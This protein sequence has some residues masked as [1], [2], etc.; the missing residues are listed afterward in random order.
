[1]EQLDNSRIAKIVT[2]SQLPL[3]IYR[4]LAAHLQQVDGV[5]TEV[6]MRSE[7]SGKQVFDYQESQVESLRVEYPQKLKLDSQ[8]RIEEIIE[9]YSHRYS[10]NV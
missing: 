6:I 3:A 5:T 9:Y 4:E 10:R 7:K 8:E 1:V 2:I